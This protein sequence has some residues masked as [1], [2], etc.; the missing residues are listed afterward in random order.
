MQGTDCELR[1]SRRYD[2]TPAE[3]WAALTEP[4]SIGRWLARP[5]D[6]EVTP[7]GAFTLA[8]GIDARVVELDPERLLELDWAHGSEQRSLV[9]FELHADA[10]GN[11]TVLTLEHSR[12]HA[13]LGMAYMS[14]WGGALRRL[15]E[16]VAR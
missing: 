13:P 14:R 16:E 11:G 9:R 3:V 1:I 5:V 10:D 2:A 7:G 12:I 6:L 8:N 15:D 4:E